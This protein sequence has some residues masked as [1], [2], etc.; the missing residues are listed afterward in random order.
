[1]IYREYITSEKWRKRKQFYFETH[2]RKCRACGSLK[3]IHLHHKTYRRL[4][5]ERDADLVP[6]CHNCHTSL[7]REQKR[8]EENLW[9]FTEKF[10]RNKKTNK[11]KKN[12]SLKKNKP[13]LRRKRKLK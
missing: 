11:F 2:D 6:L 8:S 5:E 3:R 4:G 12:K 7:H 13:L 10:I 1:M 9:I